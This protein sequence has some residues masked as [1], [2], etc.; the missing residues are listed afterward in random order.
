MGFELRIVEPGIDR[1][2]EVLDDP[3]G[4][5]FGAPMPNHAVAS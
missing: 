1:L 4:R 3:V 2:V 5:I